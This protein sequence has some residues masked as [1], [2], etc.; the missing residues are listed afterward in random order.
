MRIARE[1]TKIDRIACPRLVA[2]FIDQNQEPLSAPC[3][4]LCHRIATG[5]VSM[6]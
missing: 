6:P 1:R 2:R 4:E 3:G 5:A